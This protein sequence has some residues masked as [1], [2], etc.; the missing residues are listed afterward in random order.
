VDPDRREFSGLDHLVT[1]AG[2][3]PSGPFLETTDEGGTTPDLLVA[4]VVRL[5]RESAEHLQEGDGG[6][7]VTIASRSVKEAI[8]SLMPAERRP[9]GCVGTGEH[10]LEKL[11]PEIPRQRCSPSAPRD[12]PDGRA[13]RAGASS[14]AS[15]SPTNRASRSEGA[16]IPL[17]R[18]GDP[19]ELGDVVAYFRSGRVSSTASRYPSTAA[20]GSVEPVN[21]SLAARSVVGTPSTRGGGS[22]S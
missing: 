10:S 13:Q 18:I 19:M 17:G 6:T 12:R 5:V 2:G 22:S 3:P 14:A 4:G 1:N 20:R 7:I 11:A 16:P 15:T 9:H 21:R 8:P